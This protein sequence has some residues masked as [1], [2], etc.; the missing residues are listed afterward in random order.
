[1]NESIIKRIKDSDVILPEHKEAIFKLF[2]VASRVKFGKISPRMEGYK[3][4]DGKYPRCTNVLSM[5]GTKAAA[6]SEWAK[7]E[8]VERAK[9]SLK[10]QLEEGDLTVDAID[11][12]LESA[13]EEPERQKMDA[14]IKGTDVHD[15]IEKWLNGDKYEESIQLDDFKAI[16]EKEG[17]TLVCTE[18]PLVWSADGSNSVGF[19]G[20]M[21]ILGYKD[22]K[23]II[24]DNKTSKSVHTSYALQVAAYKAA[25][26]QMSQGLIQ[27]ATAKI[28]HVPDFKSLSEYQMKAYKRYGNLVECKNLDVAFEHF[29]VLLNQ[30]Q[31]RNNKY[32]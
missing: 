8:V 14:A 18:L 11:V 22:G 6:L 24:Y 26:E 20:R 4:G 27:I 32:Y 2:D 23:F 13:I 16:W 9:K 5:D 19:G 12:L 17:A 21:D 1:M 25:V 30:Y 10:E 29:K 31:M 15:N 28:I 7:R 3:L